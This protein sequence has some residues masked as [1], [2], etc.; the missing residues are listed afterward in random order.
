[1]FHTAIFLQLSLNFLQF[2]SDSPPFLSSVPSL[3]DLIQY[4]VILCMNFWSVA[5]TKK[6]IKVLKLFTKYL[7]ISVPS[8]ICKRKTFQSNLEYL[9]PPGFPSIFLK[10]S[11]LNPPACRSMDAGGSMVPAK[12]LE[13]KYIDF[14]RIFTVQ[15]PLR[16]PALFDRRALI[17]QGSMHIFSAPQ[18]PLL[19]NWVTNPC[20]FGQEH[21]IRME[22]SSFK[23]CNSCIHCDVVSMSVGRVA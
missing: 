17:Q 1:M 18:S 3:R 11:N 6:T 8:K 4:V 19:R 22:S 5:M 23:F 2:S 7:E 13:S 9:F 16:V 10:T 14:P 15:E 12:S 20:K 21:A